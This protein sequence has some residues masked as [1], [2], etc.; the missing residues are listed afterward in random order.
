ML[1]ALSS[2]S[3]ARRN[4]PWF[5]QADD[6]IAKRTQY[7]RSHR[8]PKNR[9]RPRPNDGQPERNKQ[10]AVVGIGNSNKETEQIIKQ[11][12]TQFKAIAR[13]R[14]HFYFWIVPICADRLVCVQ[15]K[16]H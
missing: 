1:K 4:R 9:R 15:C 2:G 11:K 13:I 12:C 3:S 7:P 6:D 14:V 8:F 16:K 5:G 10:R